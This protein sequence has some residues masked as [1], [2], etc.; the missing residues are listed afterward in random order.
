M[1]H[2]PFICAFRFWLETEF[3]HFS[4]PILQQTCTAKPIVA[5]PMVNIKR[6]ELEN[7]LNR[8]WIE[9]RPLK[10]S[11]PLAFQPLVCSTDSVTLSVSFRQ[12]EV[13]TPTGQEQSQSVTA[14]SLLVF[15]CVLNKVVPSFLTRVKD[16]QVDVQA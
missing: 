13:P 4:A 1:H 7:G 12:L 5:A 2:F 11:L 9:H 3:D 6:N 14:V 16:S 15:F 10:W 8:P